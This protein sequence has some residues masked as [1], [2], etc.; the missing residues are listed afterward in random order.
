MGNVF[1]MMDMK[2]VADT[3]IDIDVTLLMWKRRTVGV[4]CLEF[5]NYSI[6]R[7]NVCTGAYNAIKT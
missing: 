4:R 2:I 6:V 1:I 7:M 3:M 5:E